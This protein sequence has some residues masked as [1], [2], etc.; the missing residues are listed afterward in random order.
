M[1]RSMVARSVQHDAGAALR[2]LDRGRIGRGD[3]EA[4][5]AVGRPDIGRIASGPARNHLDPVRHHE[6]G[7]EAHAEAADEGGVFLGLRRLQAIEE[8]LGT[9]AGNGAE[10]FGHLLAGHA[11]AVVFDR[12]QTFVGIERDGD[13]RLWIVAQK[14]GCGDCLVAQALASVGGVGNQLA[15]KNRLLRI[16]RVHHK[17]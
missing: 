17:L 7:I 14:R 8:R 6:G 1:S 15:Q 12:Q 9:G 16:N 3:G 10:R 13:A 2:R 4:T 5:L 11:D